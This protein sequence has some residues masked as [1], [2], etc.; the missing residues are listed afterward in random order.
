MLH[1]RGEGL[2]LDTQNALSWLSEMSAE[3]LSAWKSWKRRQI[4]PLHGSLISTSPFLLYPH[5]FTMV[6]M[7]PVTPPAE[8]S[9]ENA[10]HK[11]PQ[12]SHLWSITA[13]CVSNSQFA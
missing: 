8:E 11:T 12:K 9:S 3:S 5:T 10:E 7:R 4:F 1:P 6:I 13:F 2:I